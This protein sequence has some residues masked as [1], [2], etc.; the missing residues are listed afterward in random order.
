MFDMSTHSLRDL[1]T[2]LGAIVRAVAYTGEETII[3]DSGT[4]NVYDR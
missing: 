4:E 2:N 3:T 1:R